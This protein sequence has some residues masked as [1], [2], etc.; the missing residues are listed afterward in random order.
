MP[1]G[2]SGFDNER[3]QA[4]ACIHCLF[5]LFVASVICIHLHLW[6]NFLYNENYIQGKG[7][8]KVGKGKEGAAFSKGTFNTVRTVITTHITR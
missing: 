5:A 1:C 3:F 7:C 4:I 6:A 8:R 2:K